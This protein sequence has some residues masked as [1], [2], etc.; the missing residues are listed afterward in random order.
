MI[1]ARVKVDKL[2]YRKKTA[3]MRQSTHVRKLSLLFCI[4]AILSRKSQSG[5]W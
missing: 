4:H 1:K 2:F 3:S 5:K